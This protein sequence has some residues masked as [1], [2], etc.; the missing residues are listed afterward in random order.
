MFLKR[1]TVAGCTCIAG[2]SVAAQYAAL[3]PI[4]ADPGPL[5]AYGHLSVSEQHRMK[6][7]GGDYQ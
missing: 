6:Q 4:G 2:Y 3:G 5:G 1:S 7:R